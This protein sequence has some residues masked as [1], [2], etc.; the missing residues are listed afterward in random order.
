MYDKIRSKS[1][2]LARAHELPKTYKLFQ[3]FHHLFFRITDTIATTHYSVGK[4]LAELIKL[5]SHNSYSL[6]D[7]F[8]AI[9]KISRI[10][11]QAVKMMYTW[12]KVFKNRPSKVCGRQPFINLNG[13]GLQNF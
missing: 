6:K 8:G 11:P 3:L 2:K 13:Y 7:S 1:F 4:S 10:F 5:L 12:H 9:T